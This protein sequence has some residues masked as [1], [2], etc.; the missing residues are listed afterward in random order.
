MSL[1]RLYLVTAVQQF[2]FV[3]VTEFFEH[4][5]SELTQPDAKDWEPW[6]SLPYL[7]NPENLPMFEVFFSKQ[8]YHTLAASL[9]NFLATVFQK[10]PLPKLLAFNIE[11]L[12]RKATLSELRAL[13]AERAKLLN[14]L[15]AAREE[16]D[17]L[18]EHGYRI[19]KRPAN[20]LE[21]MERLRIP[22]PD[23]A[24]AISK[25][26]VEALMPHPPPASP[27]TSRFTEPLATSGLEYEAPKTFVPSMALVG[28]D[29]FEVQQEVLLGH[30]SRIIK[31]RFSS[32]G[33]K[34]A[35]GSY[36]GTVRVWSLDF[37]LLATR[38]D[39]DRIRSQ[40]ASSQTLEDGEEVDVNPCMLESNISLRAA[41]LCFAWDEKNNDRFLLIGSNKHSV[42]IWNSDSRKLIADIDMKDREF[43]FVLDLACSPS[44]LTLVTA[45]GGREHDSLR[46][47]SGALSVWSLKKNCRQGIL[48][49]D[50]ELSQ[51]NSVTFNHNGNMLAAGG[52]DGCVR[53]YDMVTF[54]P[55]MKWHAHKGQITDVH[56]SA[57]QNGVFSTGLDGQVVKWSLHARRKVNCFS[58]PHSQFLM[59]EPIPKHEIALDPDSLRFISTGAIV[60]NDAFLFDSAS[61]NPVQAVRGHSGPVLT[62][63]WHPTRSIVLTGSTDHTARLTVLTK[64]SKVD[65]QSSATG[66]ESAV[67]DPRDPALFTHYS[68][69]RPTRPNY[70]ADQN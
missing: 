37:D 38:S 70:K 3:K 66:N 4:F 8:W 25:A 59:Q 2:N 26:S 15:R 7:R 57:D 1:R 54:A 50:C 67:N 36:D 12:E 51:I 49:V 30:R 56:F 27:S 13:R 33:T 32:D 18:R 5:A 60:N 39:P 23:S 40:L 45:C 46:G 48:H 20:L 47:G 43:P 63:D 44:D 14:E 53:L 68:S 64:Q 34:A 55:I 11:R 62:V 9:S 35:T 69:K 58:L 22:V 28:D 19:F 61:R 21:Q 41:P 29:P 24:T 6:F 31:T 16:I 65:K 52:A 42:K 17:K 10:I